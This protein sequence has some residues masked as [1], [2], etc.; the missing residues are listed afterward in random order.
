MLSSLQK[1]ASTLLLFLKNVKK[2]SVFINDT[3]SHTPR[4]VFSTETSEL[5]NQNAS[6][7]IPEFVAGNSKAQVTKEAFYNKLSSIPPHLMPTAE[8]VVEAVSR[9]SSSNSNSNSNSDKFEG[10]V[11]REKFAVCSLIGGEQ[12][13]KMATNPATQHLRLVPWAGVA[14]LIGRQHFEIIGNEER[15]IADENEDVKVDERGEIRRKREGKVF[16]FLPLPVETGLPVHVHACF[17]LSSN[18]RDI[19]NIVYI[20]INYYDQIKIFCQEKICMAKIN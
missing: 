8:Y 11:V 14:S 17:E 12:L 5:G 10:R 15:V 18:R 19:H 7:I 3:D 16:C 9:F 1:S 20:S 4:L 2:I 6:R 13:L